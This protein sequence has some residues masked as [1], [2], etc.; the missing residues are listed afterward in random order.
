M[1]STVLENLREDATAKL[2][3]LSKPRKSY[4]ADVIDLA[5]LNSKYKNILNYKLGDTITLIY[6][7]KKIRETNNVL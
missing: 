7:D 6:K 4:S 5:N 2:Q 1:R 3:E